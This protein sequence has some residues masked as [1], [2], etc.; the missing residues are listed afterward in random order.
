MCI[1]MPSRLGAWTQIEDGQNGRPTSGHREDD[2]R[3]SR[4]DSGKLRWLCV[5]RACQKALKRGCGHEARRCGDQFR[6]EGIRTPPREHQRGH[7]SDQTINQSTLTH[8]LCL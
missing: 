4:S 1:T 3:P 7:S 8:P 2:A 5:A 6:S